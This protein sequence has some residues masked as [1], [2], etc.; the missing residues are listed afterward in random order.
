MDTFRFSKQPACSALPP[1]FHVTGRWLFY[2][3]SPSQTS[4][5]TE[6]W[7][8]DLQTEQSEA[9][10]RGVSILE[11]DIS[12]DAR[13]AVFSTQRLGDNTQVWMAVLHRSSSP[14]LLCSAGEDSPHFG[15]NGHIVVRVTEGEV[16]TS[17]G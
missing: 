9:V 11:H 14:R 4:G 7:R 16:T 17:R 5:A 6:L 15:P 13:E 10:L 1:S 3:K 2:L 12:D 8:T